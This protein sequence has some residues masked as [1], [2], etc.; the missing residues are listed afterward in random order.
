MRDVRLSHS[1][2]STDIPRDRNSE[3]VSLFFRENN[4]MRIVNV[5]I[6]VSILVLCM[7]CQSPAQDVF[8]FNPLFTES[9]AILIPEIEGSWV[10]NEIGTDTISVRRT[11]DNFYGVRL[12]TKGGTSHYEGVFTRAGKHILLDLLPVLPKDLGGQDYGRH[13]LEVHSCIRVRL[14]NDSL[15]LGLL[16]YRWFYD[17]VIAKRSVSDYL[18]ADSRIILTLP[19]NELRK[20]LA[21]HAD[22]SGFLEDDLAFRRVATKP[23]EVNDTVQPRMKSPEQEG[24]EGV[25]DSSQW[26][27]IPSFPYKD[28]WLGGDGGFSVPIGRSKTLWFFGDTFVGR[29]DQ[30]TR[31][32]STM[33]TTIGISTCR[34]D[35][36]FD[37]KYYWRNMYTDH[38]DPFFLSHTGRY[39][40]WQLD[41]FMYG[42]SLYVV[43]AKV[44]PK[45]GASPDDIF[46]F[47]YLG[48][49]LA[50]VI[51]PEATPPDQWNIELFPWS[52]A[53]DAE[54]Y[55]GGLTVDGNYAYIFMLKGLWK[56]Y[57]VR[58]PLAN[59]ESPDGHLEYFSQDGTW[60]PGADS[61]DAKVLFDDQLIGGVLYQ[62]E[63]KRWIMVYGPHFGGKTVYYRTAPEITGPW[64]DK[65]TL[66]ECPELIEGT[67]LYEKDNYCYFARIHA[68]FIE[69]DSNLL[70]TYCCNSQ[71]LSK[72][73]GN[74]TIDVP[75]VL[76]ISAP[77]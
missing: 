12:I 10:T 29:K 19:S 58:L 54:S 23:R 47:K 3:S 16:K 18:L 68:Q 42:N 17:N 39:R 44:G 5:F 65:H 49:A 61:A 15:H 2:R 6:A 8:S 53:L 9:D 63:L 71:K 11:G 22:E 4:L 76:V 30:V 38:P 32:G 57:V 14:E 35:K 34:P 60:H 31:Q 20:F 75:K 24:N 73:V 25:V 21:E 66:Y 67:P 62:R 43:M 77:R 64:S 52:G 28:G 50:K 13:L 7:F 69:N 27:C 74:M 36:T 40:Y 51:D 48:L 45:L 26:G 37:M 72:L 56:N 46:N 1:G 59:M 33:V 41:A 70:I 55:D